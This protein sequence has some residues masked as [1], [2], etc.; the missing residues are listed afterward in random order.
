VLTIITGNFNKRPRGTNILERDLPP[1]RFIPYL[2]DAV[3]GL[4]HCG[5]PHQCE[6]ESFHILL[7]SFT[8]VDK[9]IL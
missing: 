9:G 8:V 7:F 3:I 1:F 5:E 4:G 6:C 2:S